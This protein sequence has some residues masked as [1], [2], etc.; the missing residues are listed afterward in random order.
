VAMLRAEIAALHR[1]QIEMLEMVH[2]L[3]TKDVPGWIDTKCERVEHRL[4]LRIA[5]QQS[6]ILGKLNEMLINAEGRAM[7]KLRER[8]FKFAGESG[9]DH[10]SDV[11]PNWRKPDVSKVN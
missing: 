3:I 2:E 11:L 8:A 9:D 4:R 5:E 6:E 10:N 1:N 7:G